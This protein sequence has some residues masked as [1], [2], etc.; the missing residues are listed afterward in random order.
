MSHKLDGYPT[1]TGWP[2]RS[3]LEHQQMYEAWIQRAWE[4]GLRVIHADIGNSAKTDTKA[5]K[6]D[7]AEVAATALVPPQ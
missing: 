6:K 2:K 4:G 7:A 5:K 3:T 1:F